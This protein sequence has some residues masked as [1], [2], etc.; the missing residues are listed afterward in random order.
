MPLPIEDVPSYQKLFCYVISPNIKTD[1]KYM[2]KFQ[3]RRCDNG[4][5]Q[6]RGSDLTES[7]FPIISDFPF[8]SIIALAASCNIIGVVID[9]TNSFQNTILY[10]ADIFYVPMPPYYLQWFM[11]CYLHINIK[12]SKWGL[13]FLQACNVIQGKK[14]AALNWW[15]S[16]DAVL[17]YVVLINLPCEQAVCVLAQD[18]EYMIMVLSTDELLCLYCESS[19]FH[20]LLFHMCKLFSC[21]SQ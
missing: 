16:L 15:I 8:S 1:D 20:R 11:W 10:P 4:I 12:D 18:D 17:N 2:W 7:F 13:H 19:T 9:D 5:T 14:P 21:T 3:S 6:I